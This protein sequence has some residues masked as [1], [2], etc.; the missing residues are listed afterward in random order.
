MRMYNML[1]ILTLTVTQGLNHENN[2][3]LIISE[4]VQ[5]MPIELA[6]K[7]LRLK[8]GVYYMTIASL[9]TLTFTQGH[10]CVSN[11]AIFQLV[12]SHTIFKILHSNLA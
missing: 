11:L 12:M 2:K 10:N 6:V 5:A 7:I 4:T 1:I 8:V 3:C 9:M